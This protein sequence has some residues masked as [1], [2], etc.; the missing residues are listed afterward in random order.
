MVL[1]EIHFKKIMRRVHF[2]SGVDSSFVRIESMRF[3]IESGKY[4]EFPF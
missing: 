3:F 2:H 1:N 4:S